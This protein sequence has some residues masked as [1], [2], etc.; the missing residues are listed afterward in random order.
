MFICNINNYIVRLS[1]KFQNVLGRFGV[2]SEEEL[3]SGM[4]ISMSKQFSE[5]E[6]YN[7][8]FFTTNRICL[9]YSL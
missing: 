5:N 6:E 9:L 2:T 7:G 8:T 3:L 4:I 1:L